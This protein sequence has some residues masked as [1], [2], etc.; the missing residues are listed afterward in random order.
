MMNKN[1]FA[2]F[3]VAIF[4]CF[5]AAF[6]GSAFTAPAIPEWYAGIEKPLFAPPNWVFAPVW[7]VLFLLMG[8]SLYIV[9]NKGLKKRETVF[10]VFVFGVQLFLN[11][12]WSFFFFGLRNP[13]LA[14]VEIILLWFFVLATTMFFYRES[15]KAGVLLFPYLLWTSFA[16]FLNYNIWILNL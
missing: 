16:A 15:R 11:V 7:T 9:W 2:K 12:L 4:V 10:A 3:V 14:F 6:I 1:K 8:F 13:F 5:L